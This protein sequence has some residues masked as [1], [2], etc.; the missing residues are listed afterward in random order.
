MA[1]LPKTIIIVTSCTGEKQYKPD[2][3]LV[4]HDF[5]SDKDAFQTRQEELAEYCLPAEEMYTGQQHLR[6]MRGIEALRVCSVY[7]IDLQI[8]SAGYGLITGDTPVAPYE[9]T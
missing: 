5:E 9:C 6:L 3:Q 4:K 1:V 8:V 2:N 7:H